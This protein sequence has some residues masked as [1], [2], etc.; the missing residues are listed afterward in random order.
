MFRT[1]H[2]LSQVGGEDNILIFQDFEDEDM[3]PAFFTARNEPA[4]GS[5]IDFFLVKFCYSCILRHFTPY[6]MFP[7][8]QHLLEDN[9]DLL[10]VAELVAAIC[11]W[12]IE[13]PLSFRQYPYE[14]SMSMQKQP[15]AELGQHW[16][17]L[18]YLAG[19]LSYP[20]V[21]LEARRCLHP[22]PSP[23]CLSQMG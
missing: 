10:E 1:S 18:V 6:S 21:I 22:Q 7:V 9:P 11:L 19:L 12:Y 16:M 23:L 2:Y 3:I 20:L 5:N 14:E 15:F 17:G 8:G 4:H 13:L